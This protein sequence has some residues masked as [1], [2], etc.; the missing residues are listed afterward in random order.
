MP[1][2]SPYLNQ[3]KEIGLVKEET[4]VSETPFKLTNGACLDRIELRYECYGKLNA[5]KD[6]AIYICHALTGDHHVAGIYHE[7]DEKPGWWNH[8]VGPG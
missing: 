5:Q 1:A 2:S 7:A 8:V 6:N 3:P 4:F